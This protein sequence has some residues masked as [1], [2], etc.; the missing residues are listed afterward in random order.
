M[1]GQLGR[2]ENPPDS[3]DADHPMS[4]ALP[5]VLPARPKKKVWRR[6]PK[7]LNQSWNGAKPRCVGFA[8]ANWKQALPTYTTVSNAVGDELYLAC[9]AIDGYA[10]DG[11]YDRALM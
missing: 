6:G 5:M 10:G 2:I 4:A 9:K 7:R 1:T 8:G 11:T 3:R